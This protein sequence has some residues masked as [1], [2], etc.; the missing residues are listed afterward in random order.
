MSMA[1]ALADKLDLLAGFFAIGE[2]PTGSGDPYA[3]RRA[4]A[5]GDPHRPRE[6]LAPEPDRADR[7]SRASLASS[8]ITRQLPTISL[9]S[10]PSVCEFNCAR[11]GDAMTALGGVRRTSGRRFQPVA[12][13]RQCSRGIAWHE[14]GENLLTAYRR[15]ANILRIEARKDGPHE[16]RPTLRCFVSRRSNCWRRHWTVQSRVSGTC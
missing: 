7:G 4:G 2:K 12:G 13:T 11:K 15:A 16:S 1:I 9:T 5:G 6:R 10:W 8:G 3:L 14:T